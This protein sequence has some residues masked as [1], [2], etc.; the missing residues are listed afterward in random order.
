MDLAVQ[1]P[2]VFPVLA[3]GMLPHTDPFTGP[4]SFQVTLPAGVTCAGCTLQVLEFMQADVGASGNCFYHHCA[5]LRI[6]G[7]P[8]D[9][10]GDGAG[11]GAPWGPPGD[12]GGC[13]CG[14][15]GRAHPSDAILVM[16][17]LLLG[18]RRPRPPR[19]CGP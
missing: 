7:P 10:G 19:R 3:D 6:S 17:A 9:A 8:V 4:Q 13:G 1:D 18:A 15:G 5:D 11:G 14:L 16:A 12:T 2:P